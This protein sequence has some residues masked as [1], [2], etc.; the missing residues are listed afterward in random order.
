MSTDANTGK[1]ST[2]E[3]KQAESASK[4]EKTPDANSASENKDDTGK[5]SEQDQTKQGKKEIDEKISTMLEQFK[6]LPPDDAGLLYLRSVEERASLQ[7]QLDEINAAK[8]EAENQ[9][10]KSIIDELSPHM[11]RLG[12]D[13]SSLTNSSGAEFDRIVQSTRVSLKLE[14]EK[15]ELQERLSKMETEKNSVG[16]KRPGS[17]LDLPSGKSKREALEEIEQGFRNTVESR[18]LKGHSDRDFSKIQ[19]ESV[20][21][22]KQSNGKSESNETNG[23]SKMSSL[24]DQNLTLSGRLSKLDKNTPVTMSETEFLTLYHNDIKK[25]AELASRGSNIG[26]VISGG[27]RKFENDAKRLSESS[28]EY[29]KLSDD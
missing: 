1:E 27:I 5:K 15:K 10:K 23:S 7:K 11:D 13:K 26:P 20:K 22:G 8:I 21:D 14:A 3:K 18:N 9:K 2:V 6:G 24:I 19:Q 16:Q 17:T 12:L 29:R 28:K 25:I 4:Q